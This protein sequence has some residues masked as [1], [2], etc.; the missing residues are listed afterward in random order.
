M[1]TT[2]FNDLEDAALQG[3]PW[4]AQVLYLRGIRRFMSYK[5][6]VV[7]KPAGKTISTQSLCEV[8]D[9]E[10]LPGSKEKGEK[11]T[12]PK[13]RA[14]ITMLERAGLIATLP[15]SSKENG[16]VFK[17]LLATTDN[18]VSMRNSQGTA[19]SNSPCNVVNFQQHSD[20]EQPTV[21][22]EEQPTTVLPLSLSLVP[23]DFEIKQET[24]SWLIKRGYPEPTV[25][26][27]DLFVTVYKANGKQVADWQEQFKLFMKMERDHKNKKK[28][29]STGKGY[30]PMQGKVV[31]TAGHKEFGKTAM[32]KRAEPEKAAKGMQSVREAIRG[33]V[34]E[35]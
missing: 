34:S 18:S 30:Q 23:S 11:L 24:F 6:G 26:H 10:V 9:V 15:M 5:T 19:Q 17:C 22:Q 16:Y 28:K 31:F 12:R 29:E 1:P 35:S 2:S 8:L 14:I 4:R 13:I 21:N 32:P 25:E 27:R 33:K 3:L 20:G 7:G